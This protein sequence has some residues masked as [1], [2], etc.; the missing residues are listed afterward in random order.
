MVISEPRASF[1]IKSIKA[2]YKTLLIIKYKDEKGVEH[3]NHFH[4]HIKDIDL[5]TYM[6]ATRK[7][8]IIDR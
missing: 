2:D 6:D 5:N 1:K 4:T 8:K 7:Y 3:I